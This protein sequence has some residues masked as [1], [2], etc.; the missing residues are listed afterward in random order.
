[1]L[2]SKNLLYYEEIMSFF[3]P[4]GIKGNSIRFNLPKPVYAK[5]LI[6]SNLEIK[7]CMKL[8]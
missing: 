2:K 7:Y 1:M 8:Q 5:Y 4:L 6:L 3:D